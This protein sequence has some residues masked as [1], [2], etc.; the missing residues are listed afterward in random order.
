MSAKPTVI[1]VKPTRVRKP[2]AP[3]TC[4][5][6]HT[7]TCKFGRDHQWA[8][9]WLGG[10]LSGLGVG[11]PGWHDSEICAGCLG[12]CTADMEEGGRP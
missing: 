2:A 10:P 7:D 6:S 12:V 5:P 3:R 1:R 9:P 8:S 4:C 11:E